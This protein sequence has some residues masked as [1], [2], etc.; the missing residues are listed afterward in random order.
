M[1]VEVGSA[2]A[3]LRL[4][5]SEF[6]NGVSN[7]NSALKDMSSRFNSYGKTLTKI[8]TGLTAGVTVPIIGIGTSAASTASNF[9]SSMSKVQA[10]SAATT[11]E[12]QALTD[13]A[14]EMGAK[15]KFSAKESAD[16][17][18]YMAMAGWDAQEM[19][20]GISGIMSLAAAD[21]LD[22][23]T[24]SDIV[25]DALTAFGLQASDSAHFA[26]V[27]AQASS[28][29]NTNVE[30]LGES[31]KFAAPVAGALGFSV[32]DVSIALGLMAN[33]G[34]K[35]SQAGTAL[36]ASLANLV[37]PTDDMAAL[38]DE[39][40]IE[41]TN[42]D[43][44]MKS[45]REI[46]G[47][48]RVSFNELSEAEKSNA[49]ATLFGKEAMSGM[50]AIINASEDD[51]NSLAD[52]I[53]NAD[54]RAESMAD[55]MMDNVGGSIEE[56][57]GAV[58]T[59]MIS[60]GSALA[61][62]IR[63]VAT[64][65]T[66]VV[67]KLNSM[68]DSQKEAIVQIG[69][70]AAAI[71]PLLI[72][73]GS[74]M[75]SILAIKTA[76]AALS[77]PVGWV[78]TIIGLIT[79]EIMALIKY[80]ADARDTMNEL[81]QKAISNFTAVQ[82]G[83]YNTSK[84]TQEMISEVDEWRQTLDETKSARQGTI[85]DLNAQEATC[86]SLVSRL[87]ELQSK[88]SLTASEQLEQKNIVTQLNGAMEGLNLSIDS[89]TGK[90]NMSTEALE[91]NIEALHRQAVAQAM[92]E[93]LTAIAKN[94]YEVEKKLYELNKQKEEQWIA[95]KAAEQDY[96][97]AQAVVM[98]DYNQKNWE[99]YDSA[100]KLYESARQSYGGVT[101]EIALVL[102]EQESLSQEFQVASDYMSTYADSTGQVTDAYGELGDAASQ[103][104]YDISNMSSEASE[105]M[106]QLYYDVSKA[107][108]SQMDL[109]SEF[110]AKMTLSGEQMLKNMES[111]VEGIREW[112]DNIQM[113]AERGIDQGLLQS[114]AELGPSGAGYVKSFVDMTDEELQKAN[115]TFAES[116]QLSSEISEK[117]L[118]SYAE[119]G[120]SAAEGF[121]DGY[122]TGMSDYSKSAFESTVISAEMKQQIRN[123]YKEAGIETV[124]GYDEGMQSYYGTLQEHSQQI[125]TSVLDTLRTTLDMH[126]PSRVMYDEGVNTISGYVNGINDN[127]DMPSKSINKM[128]SE[129]LSLKEQSYS[130]GKTLFENFWQGMKDVWSQMSAWINDVSKQAA[131]VSASTSVDGSHKDG[132]AYVPY[133][134]YVAELH[135]GERV[136]TK[137][138]NEDY[139]NSSRTSGGDTFIFNSPKQIDEYEAARLLRQT[140]KELAFQ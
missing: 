123:Q 56:L 96:L 2:V 140:K 114:L 70:V 28:S 17:F 68:S 64:A 59:F 63:K 109:F 104:G 47:T 15:T 61:P 102:N 86:K 4:D 24:T 50:L 11:E 74:L 66:N 125:P 41:V 133:D 115:E 107:I 126:S 71:G 19:I 89:Q 76:L 130:V 127:I 18:T 84:A 92:Q 46:L 36:R 120:K 60:I 62:M 138:E 87:K 65:I 51:F 83:I 5:T 135:E 7:A 95:Y 75:R 31:F 23:A 136:L 33:S 121:T 129:M 38:M 111:Q 77:G 108:T 8:G 20:D 29:A 72:V 52:A 40:G 54:G 30:L 13:K 57:K 131:N 32:E 90:L 105:A 78:I 137:D 21:G 3:Y 49:A 88:T 69:L 1:S 117:I 48:I 91:D 42:A 14:V 43:G 94:Q 106:T 122:T 53:D 67:D 25:T 10:I 79:T 58:E 97:D 113:L 128:L 9:E 139:S 93:D 132:L 118:L 116:T 110:D 124:A 119:A 6:T 100:R 44:T 82:S 22:L 99:A 35:G 98:A 34:L 27:L 81:T 80:Q 45:L 55:T 39:L 101:Q 112:S 12:M 73:I 134:G 16:A 85:D 103:A 26:D 37:K